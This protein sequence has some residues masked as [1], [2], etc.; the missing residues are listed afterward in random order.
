MSKKTLILILVVSLVKVAAAQKGEKSISAGPFLSFPQKLYGYPKVGLGLE[1]GGQYNFT[2]HSS[3]LLQSQLY[4]YSRKQYYYDNLTFLS[5]KG[6]YRFQ[7]N[8]SGIYTNALAGIDLEFPYPGIGLTVGAGN[9]FKL[10]DAFFI[11]AGIEYVEVNPLR[12]LNIK[13]TFGLLRRPK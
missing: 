12:R 3:L 2:N 11:D 13:A 7:F 9:R 1:V 5:L 4:S 6:G 10:K 8:N